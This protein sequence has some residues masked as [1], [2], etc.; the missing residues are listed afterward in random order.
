MVQWWKII[1]ISFDKIINRSFTFTI[2]LKKDQKKYR[3]GDTLGPVKL[4]Q[5]SHW[6]LARVTRVSRVTSLTRF[7]E[8]DFT[9]LNILL[10]KRV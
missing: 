7:Y 3:N 5:G 4:E 6:L 10:L 1:M 2:K 8:C 9:I